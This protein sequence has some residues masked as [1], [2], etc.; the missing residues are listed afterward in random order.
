M[1][2][3]KFNPYATTD[4]NSPIDCHTPNKNIEGWEDKWMKMAFEGATLAEQRDFIRNLLS[5]QRSNLVKEI[6]KMDWECYEQ[7]K[8]KKDIIN[9]INSS[10]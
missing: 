10:K 6:E 9:L 7:T 3:K 8:I 4:K 1:K 5:A 2:N